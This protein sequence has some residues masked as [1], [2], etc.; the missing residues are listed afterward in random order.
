MKKLAWLL[1]ILLLL[2][3]GFVAAGP[4]L[5]LR[6]LERAAADNRIIPLVWL[7]DYPALRASLK[8]QIGDRMVRAAG[9]G[10]QA[11]LLG[12]AGLRASGA[13]V[14]AA[15]EAAV[16]PVAIAALVQGRRLH[17][18]LP[19]LPLIGG[20]QTRPGESGDPVEAAGRPLAAA[21]Y[22]YE[23]GSRFTAT[24][25]HEDGTRTIFVLSR[26]GLCWRLSDIRLPL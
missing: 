2:M 21:R 14:D 10:V 9:S 3:A 4:V 7:V 15:V 22:R 12:Q 18:A 1:A 17:A 25:A 23:S 6:S 26:K 11:S 24:L 20:G 19:E 16:N 13:A 8:A 5:T